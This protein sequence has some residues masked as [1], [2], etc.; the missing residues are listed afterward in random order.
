MIFISSSFSSHYSSFYS[1]SM[2][3]F[4]IA[5]IAARKSYEAAF[6]LSPVFS[7]PLLFPAL[8]SFFSLAL[9]CLIRLACYLFTSLFAS[10]L[11]SFRFDIKTSLQA[12]ACFYRAFLLNFRPQPSG[13]YIKSFSPW[14][15]DYST[16]SSRIGFSSWDRMIGFSGS[17]SGMMGAG[18]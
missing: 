11:N 18:V 2:L 5:L 16:S 6:Q 1:S 12:L 13:H 4:L 14:G 17:T 3:S 9:T 15:I 7:K 8:P 10:E